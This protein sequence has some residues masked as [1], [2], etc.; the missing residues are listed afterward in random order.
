MF[1]GEGDVKLS[2]K[3]NWHV[4]IEHFVSFF[5][6]GK[7]H[8]LLMEELRKMWKI[9]VHLDPRIRRQDILEFQPGQPKGVAPC[10]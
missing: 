10:C 8:G 4:F 2:A 1:I 7:K 5:I 3:L 9:T 6:Y